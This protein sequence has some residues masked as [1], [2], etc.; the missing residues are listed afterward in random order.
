MIIEDSYLT[1]GGARVTVTTDP[2]PHRYSHWTCS[3]CKAAETSPI[4]VDEALRQA[5]RHADAC[6]VRPPR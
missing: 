6:H 3:G 1:V 2:Y 5:I 4:R